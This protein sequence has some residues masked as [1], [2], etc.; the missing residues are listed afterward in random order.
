MKKANI[1]IVCTLFFILSLGIAPLSAKTSPTVSGSIVNGYRI[2]PIEQT[3]GVVHLTVYRGDYVKF[4][5]SPAMT[6][7]VLKIPSLKVEETLPAGLDDAPYFKMK[8][9]GT[10]AFSLGSVTGDITVI[11]YQQPNYTEVT[12]EEAA[13]L[14]ANIQPLVLDVRTPRE[15]QNG[16]LENSLLIPVQEL[17][18]RWKEIAE[19]KN[20]DI[21]IYCATGNRSTVSSKIL[22]D[23]GFKRIY[24]LRYGI[25]DWTRRG[26]PVVQ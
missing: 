4:G 12:A 17:Q 13:V 6:D 21:L 25:S 24:N 1:F 19:Y 8:K 2:I 15:Y 9:P 14:I 20:Q 7:P 3:S 10:V 26:Y 11:D 5:F 16:H 22:I 23:K 18:N